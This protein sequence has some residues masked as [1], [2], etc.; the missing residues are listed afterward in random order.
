M[1]E[2]TGRGATKFFERLTSRSLSCYSCSLDVSEGHGVRDDAH[3]VA[4]GPLAGVAKKTKGQA[5][6]PVPL[7]VVADGVE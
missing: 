4:F 7:S 5:L 2:R 1:A 6:Q 3:G